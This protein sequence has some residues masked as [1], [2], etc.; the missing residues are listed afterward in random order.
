[1]VSLIEHFVSDIESLLLNRSGDQ[2]I[3]TYPALLEAILGAEQRPRNR[4]L[5]TRW[6]L[7]LGSV[8][9]VWCITDSC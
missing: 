9:T 7:K 3:S 5:Y 8:L 4:L 1:M 2:A 6:A